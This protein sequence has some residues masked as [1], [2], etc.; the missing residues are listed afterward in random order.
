MENELSSRNWC[1]K[2]TRLPE[3]KGCADHKPSFRNWLRPPQFSDSVPRTCPGAWGVQKFG[4]ESGQH[5]RTSIRWVR[6]AAS[7]AVLAKTRT[8]AAPSLGEG[9]GRAIRSP[10]RKSGQSRGKFCPVVSTMPRVCWAAGAYGFLQA[11][12]KNPVEL[13][14]TWYPWRTSRFGTGGLAFA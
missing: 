11:R 13:A 3:R 6:G 4:R 8:D 10:V 14:L 7:A 1:A 9:V 2:H 5:C 12:P